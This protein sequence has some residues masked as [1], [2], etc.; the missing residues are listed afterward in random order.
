MSK[1]RKTI[2]QLKIEALTALAK[3]TPAELNKAQM[4]VERQRARSLAKN[5]ATRAWGGTSR[6]GWPTTPLTRR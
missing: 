5:A 6:G 1:P 4:F 2:E 3:L